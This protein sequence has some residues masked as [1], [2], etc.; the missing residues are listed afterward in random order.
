MHNT[1]ESG[2][3]HVI[4]AGGGFAALEAATALKALAGDRL[5]LTVVSPDLCFRYRPTATQEAV[6]GDPPLAYDLHRLLGGLGARHRVGR[7]VAAYPQFKSLLMETGAEFSYDTLILAM[8]AVSRGV[9]PG[10]LTFRDQRDSARLRILL[11]RARRGEVPRLVFAVPSGQS[12]SLP[13]YELALLSSRDLRGHGQP[14]EISVASPEQDPLEVFGRETSSLISDLLAANEIRFVGGV[15]PRRVSD[16]WLELEFEA[17]LRADGVVAVPELHG[18]R[19]SGI[20]ASWHGFIP[21]DHL[22]RVE[23][24]TDVYAAGD[25]TTFPIKQGGLATQQADV[26]AHSIALAAGAPVHE[27]RPDRVLRI[28]L[29]GGS[30][31]LFLRSELD[32]FGQP[33][34]PTIERFEYGDA[35]PSTKVY[36]RYLGPYLESQASEDALEVA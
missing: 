22:G 18:H 3:R 12:W 28:R 17:P 9:I 1:R 33:S 2:R 34:A 13:A 5:R 19:I 11:H 32:E 24:L 23:G 8:G 27:L 10:A 14:S 35:P 7:L 29:L 6:G 30:H 31:P 26:V 21:V 25:A 36:A 4:I 16:G 20:P 15:N